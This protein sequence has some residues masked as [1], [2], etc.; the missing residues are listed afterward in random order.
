MLSL[1]PTRMCFDRKVKAIIKHYFIAQPTYL[2]NKHFHQHKDGKKHKQFIQYVEGLFVC[3]LV[4][5]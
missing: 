4:S 3:L 2:I 1:N 5:W